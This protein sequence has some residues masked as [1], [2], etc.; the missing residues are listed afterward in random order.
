MR[1]HQIWIQQ[2]GARPCIICGEVTASW[3]EACEMPGPMALCSRCDGEGILCHGCTAEGKIHQ[4]IKRESPEDEAEVSGFHDDQGEFVVF[5]P[6]LKIK[7]SGIPAGEIEDHVN[8]MVAK[9]Y[10]E[11]VLKD[12]PSSSS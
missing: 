12:K 1:K 2:L 10:E 11:V 9:H 6:P 3:C 7:L 8:N 5:N 4:E